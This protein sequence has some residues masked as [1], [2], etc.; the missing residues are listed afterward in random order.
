MASRKLLVVTGDYGI[1]Q[2]VKQVLGGSN[3]AIHTAYSHLDAIY[4]LNFEPFELVLVDAAMINRKTGERT[5]NALAQ[6]ERHPPLL[7]YSPKNG[8]E[9]VTNEAVVTSLDDETLSSGVARAL[10]LPT[11]NSEPPAPADPKRVT[12]SVFWRDEE[13]QTLFALG[14]SLTEVLELSEVLNRVVEAARRLTNAEEC[15]ILLPD[16][17]SGQLYLRAK[18]GID[19][20]VADNFRVKTHDT[21]AGAVYESGQTVLVNESGPQK[22]K[23]EYFVNS[24]LYVPIV[25]KGQTLGVLGVNNREKHDVFT[26]RHR[27]LLVNLATYAA[28]AIENARIHGQSIRRQHEMRT[29]IDASR[30]INATLSF[31]QA[32]PAICE[33]LSRVL[34]VGQAEIFMWA[35]ESQ[36]LRL[37]A[38]YQQTSWRSGHEPIIKLT[39]RPFVRMALE[40]RRYVLVQNDRHDLRGEQNRLQQVGAS[41]L[42]AVPI[43]GGDQVLGFVEGYYVQPIDPGLTNEGVH[44]VQRL[45]LEMM[46][47][48]SDDESRAFRLLQ[49]ARALLNADWMEYSVMQSDGASQCMQFGIGSGIWVDEPRPVIEVAGYPDVLQALDKQ[50]PLNHFDGEDNLSPGVRALFRQTL[51]RSLLALPLVGRGQTIGMA[52]FVDTWHARAFTPRE[53]DLGRAI[54][55]QA[56]TALE[57]V[58]LVRDLEASLR[59]LKETQTRLVQSA[60]LSAMGELAAAV[61]HQINN[62]LTTIV[63]DTELLLESETSETR[64]YEVLNAISRAGKRAAGVVRRLLA[65]ARPITPDTVR[66]P[67]GVMATI[68]DILALV[69]PHI[70]REDIKLIDQLPEAEFPTVFAA[71]GELND[72]WLNLI[73]NAHDAV[74]GRDTPEVG[75]S[76]AYEAANGIIEV[77]VWD[78]GPG[79]PDEII[80]EIFKPFFTTKPLGEGTGLGLHI[81]KQVV[82]RVGGTIVAQT[83]ASG[84]RFVVRLP[85]MR[86]P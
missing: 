56:A 30:A 44:R 75:I 55:G 2:Q 35:P 42:L 82:E 86:S 9:R 74:V 59:E 1:V 39:E 28:I 12:T 43:L 15:M 13:M 58:S 47:S 19:V 72:V 25:H 17:Q 18:I 68:G 48:R 34:N 11:L 16:G 37:L 32:L 14:R 52:L 66:M 57:N 3:F 22:V 50:E 21:I 76:A 71:P 63:L 80:G 83:S 81:C 73:L 10:R 53:V 38:S 5:A 78:N 46:A 6:M 60:R 54:V 69:R 36:Q 41:A 85:T 29:L 79:I 20:E 84:T 7:V 49:E 45:M 8:A 40:T 65:M 64:N 31:D 77:T 26:D 62:P 27:D 24:L 70:E 23:T 61:A 33:Q 4:Q 51:S 67:I